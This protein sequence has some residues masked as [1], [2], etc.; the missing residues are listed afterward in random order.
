VTILISGEIGRLDSRTILADT[1][2]VLIRT[3]DNNEL[4]TVN[5]SLIGGVNKTVDIV[6]TPAYN[7]VTSNQVILVDASS[8]PVTITLFTA[9]SNS[10]KELTIKK[11]DGSANAMT[12]DG[13]ESETI[14]GDLTVSTVTQFDSYDVI[15]NN[16]DWNI[17]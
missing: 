6:V 12:I 2:E 13:F 10:G 3:A 1:D 7:A 14:D 11:I 9:A 15:S 8:A 16:V 5:A 17:I 4:I